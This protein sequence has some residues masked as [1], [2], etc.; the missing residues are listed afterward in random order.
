MISSVSAASCGTE[1]ALGTRQ[2]SHLLAS[3]SSSG[4]QPMGVRD[5]NTW[6]YPKR[7]FNM[8][9][10]IKA[11]VDKKR[12]EQPV[13]PEFQ[14]PPAQP[15]DMTA[16]SR[17]VG[18][19]AVKAGMTQDWDEH[20]VRIPLTVLFVD[21]CQA[22]M[23]SLRLVFNNPLTDAMCEFDGHASDRL[24]ESSIPSFMGTGR[25]RSGRA[26]ASRKPSRP[27]R[28]ASSSSKASPSSM[29]S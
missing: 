27:R 28:Q 16:L 1:Q 18:C 3:S 29:R 12:Q 25:F 15:R 24:L 10:E 14:P 4:P 2:I 19:I 20:G 22:S 11:I 23:A 13:I 9:S 8:P 6:Q 7:V 21:D 26:I 17:R 5:Y